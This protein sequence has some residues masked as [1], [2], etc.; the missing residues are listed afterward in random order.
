MRR[1]RILFHLLVRLIRP[2]SGANVPNA[3]GE[4]KRAASNAALM[5][6]TGYE[7]FGTKSYRPA[8]AAADFATAGIIPAIFMLSIRLR[9]FSVLAPVSTHAS[10]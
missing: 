10:T 6:T 9:I 4:S 7:A 8:P 1:L 5:S 2:S 3:E